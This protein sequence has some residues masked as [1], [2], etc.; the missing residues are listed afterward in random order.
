MQESSHI[1]RQI[2][3]GFQLQQPRQGDVAILRDEDIVL[4]LSDP[5]TY[6]TWTYVLHGDI[7]K[8]VP[9][10]CLKQLDMYEP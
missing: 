2:S 9:A 5:G 10:H 8:W 7:R 6:G 3:E 4:V 1:D